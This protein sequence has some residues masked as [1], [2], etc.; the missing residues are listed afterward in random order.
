MRDG[1]LRDFDESVDRLVAL[2]DGDATAVTSALL[3]QVRAGL[4]SSVR[5]KVSGL[6]EADVDDVVG[7]AIVRF[8][9]AVLTPGRLDRQ[10]PAAA[11]LTT[12]T[13]NAA[14]DVLRRRQRRPEDQSVDSAQEAEGDDPIA[15]F[16]RAESSRAVIRAAL[17]AAA[18]HGD[19]VVT[20][21]VASWRDLASVLE[22][23]PTTR[24]VAEAAKVSHTTVRRALA[25]FQQLVA[26]SVPGDQFRA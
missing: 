14:Y 23:A 11:Y 25:R 24:E 18:E 12:I 5:G 19:Y 13:Y 15:Q 9:E 2:I 3:A 8:V 21:V 1:G 17:A 4:A 20:K 22:R 7:S 10:K 6:S 26:E 16:L